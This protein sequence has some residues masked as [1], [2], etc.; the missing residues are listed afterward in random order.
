MPRYETI[1]MLRDQRAGDVSGG[2]PYLS[3]EDA[4]ASYLVTVIPL[5]AVT[6]GSKSGR[7]FLGRKP[8]LRR[9][10]TSDGTSP[11]GKY[12]F[13]MDGEGRVFAG[14]S[15]QVDKHSAFLAG[16]PVAAAGLIVV[17]AGRLVAV[18]DESGHYM[19]PQDYLNQFLTEMVL[20]GVDRLGVKIVYHGS[21][22]A[23]IAANLRR[24][25]RRGLQ[26]E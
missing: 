16:A 15:A 20:R 6:P 17:E 22:K 19:P 7:L 14:S 13:V 18:E 21:T 25:G 8:L 23:T 24:T 2:V 1:S 12:L 3:T 9:L 4:R 26:R 5:D 10:D 11:M